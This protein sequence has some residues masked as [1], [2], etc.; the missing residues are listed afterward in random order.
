MSYWWVNHKQTYT[1][2]IK[3]GYIWS[4]KENSNGSR[5]QTYV[6]LTLTKPGDI[7]FSYAAGTIKAI[8]VIESNCQEQIK[9]SEFGKAGDVWSDIGWGVPIDWEIL[10]VPVT[11]KDHMNTIAPLLPPKH[12]PLQLNGNGNQSCYLASIQD[13]LGYFL[14]EL[15]Q[16]KNLYSIITD[17]EEGITEAEELKIIDDI[18]D[19]DIESTEKE[20]VTKARKGQGKFRK[21]VIKKENKCRLTGVI[22]KDL[23]IASHIKP[24]KVSSNLERLD[25]N[26]GLLLSPHVDKLFD[27]GWITFLDNGDLISVSKEIDEALNQWGISLPVNVGAFSL[28]Q[29]TY[30]AYHREHVFDKVKKSPVTY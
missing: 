26:N 20:Q 17:I 12:S 13:E 6:N 29:T 30:L 22:K 1:S 18:N 16:P 25:G 8:G 10:S 28:K 19:S 7:V 27:K 4:P 15:A 2:E 14:T 21:N 3:G 5:N 23:L 24:W 9:P 11:P